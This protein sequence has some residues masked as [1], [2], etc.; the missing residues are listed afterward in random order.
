MAKAEL[1]FPTLVLSLLLLTS[2]TRAFADA[3]FDGR[4]VG[5]RALTVRNNSAPCDRGE[6]SDVRLVVKH[7][8]FRLR[9][10]GQFVE[11][12]VGADGALSGGAYLQLSRTHLANV[13]VTGHAD[14]T[15]IEADYGTAACAYHLSLKKT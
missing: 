3:S 13:A 8:Q 2:A 4:Y 11:V 5:N 6:A 15:G 10:G 14:A 12:A 7:N 1:T 9:W